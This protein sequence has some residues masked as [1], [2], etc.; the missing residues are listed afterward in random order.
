MVSGHCCGFTLSVICTWTIVT[1]C[2]KYRGSK[3]DHASKGMTS[4]AI[5]GVATCRYSTMQWTSQNQFTRSFSGGYKM[6][7]GSCVIEHKLERVRCRCHGCEVESSMW[8][9]G[10]SQPMNALKMAN[11]KWFDKKQCHVCV[12]IFLFIFLAHFWLVI[13]KSDLI[14]VADVLVG[15]HEGGFTKFKVHLMPFSG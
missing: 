2:A 10:N 15:F 7:N 12:F 3:V 6:T 9:N 13:H 1:K 5:D 11:G 4:L 14:L 8:V